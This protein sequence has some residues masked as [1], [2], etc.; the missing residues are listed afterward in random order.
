MNA[1]EY[2][3]KKISKL[4]KEGYDDPKQRIAVAMS[5]ARQKGMKVPEKKEKRSFKRLGKHFGK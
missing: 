4:K 5:M 1:K 3:S 2:V